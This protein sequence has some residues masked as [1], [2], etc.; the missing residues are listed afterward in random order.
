MEN[1]LG[2]LLAYWQEVIR[3]KTTTVSSCVGRWADSM[4]RL[5]HQTPPCYQS[6]L[7][8]QDYNNSLWEKA[9]QRKGRKYSLGIGK[10]KIWI[11]GQNMGAKYIIYHC[12]IRKSRQSNQGALSDYFLP[13]HPKWWKRRRNYQAS[14]DCWA[15][16]LMVII[17]F[18]MV[19]LLRLSFPLSPLI[20]PVIIAN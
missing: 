3:L 19:Y 14:A 10:K 20:W 5:P 13:Y 15:G 12:I 6:F 16:I 17:G 11:L 9:S 1:N 8:I 4:I 18:L 2:N 7:S